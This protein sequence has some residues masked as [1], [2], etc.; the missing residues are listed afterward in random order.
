MN[1][2]IT[3]DEAWLYLLN[4]KAPIKGVVVH[5]ARQSNCRGWFVPD[6]GTVNDGIDVRDE[7]GMADGGAVWYMREVPPEM[8]IGAFKEY[9][10]TELGRAKNNVQYY[11]ER[12]KKLECGNWIEDDAE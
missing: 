9:F 12:L 10:K 8:A 1:D 4:R 6:D 11:E 3:V 7:E 2:W 5:S